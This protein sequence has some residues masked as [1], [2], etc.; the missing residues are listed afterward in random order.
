MD[1][2]PRS[3]KRGSP[4]L[5]YFSNKCNKFKLPEEK[6]NTF[7]HTLQILNLKFGKCSFPESGNPHGKCQTKKVLQC[8]NYSI[9]VVR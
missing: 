9:K 5:L 4:E 1:Y 6:T 3:S 7:T 2:L 8:I